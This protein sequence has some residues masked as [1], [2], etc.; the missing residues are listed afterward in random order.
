[1][2]DKEVFDSANKET[3]LGYLLHYAYREF[4]DGSYVFEDQFFTNKNI[5]EEQKYIIHKDITFLAREFGLKEDIYSDDENYA[6][7]LQEGDEDHFVIFNKDYTKLPN[8][9]FKLLLRMCEH[10]EKLIVYDIDY[11][12]YFPYYDCKMVADMTAF[13]GL[14]I[15]WEEDERFDFVNNYIS[16]KLEQ[17]SFIDHSSIESNKNEEYITLFIDFNCSDI[18]E[19]FVENELKNAFFDMFC[20]YFEYFYGDLLQEGDK[21]E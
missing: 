7:G 5:S 2:K 11:R 15:G 12:H 21:N 20:D 17:Y 9:I 13:L 8:F 16:T 3:R 14:F 19:D 10:M 1:M 6:G 18:S 4:C